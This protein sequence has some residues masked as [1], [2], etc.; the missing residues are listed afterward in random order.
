[1]LKFTQLE[2]ERPKPASLPCAAS[3]STLVLDKLEQL[4]PEHSEKT[5]EKGVL[6]NLS[7]RARAKYVT[8]I[9]ARPLAELKSPLQKAY[10]LSTTCAG[11]LAERPGKITS[12]YCG[13]RWC[14]VC[15]R[16]RT[17]KLING[18]LPA[19]EQMAEKWFLTLSRPNVPGTKLQDEIRY[20]LRE[21]SL[22][23]RYL[24]EKRN[25]KHYSS[26]R[27]IECTYNE[28]AQTYHPHF[29]IIFDDFE[30]ADL[31]L[32]QWL[33]RNPTAQLNKGN[34]LKKA[35]DKAVK[36]LFKYFTKV[37]SKTKSKAVNGTDSADYR[38]HLQA[39]DIMFVA[40][41]A[42]R[43]FQPCGI[44]K[45]V[46]EEIETEQALES[47]RVQVNQWSWKDYDWMNTETA[48]ALTGY[49]PSASI[50]SIS[51]HLV[52]PSSAPLTGYVDIET[53]E[54]LDLKYEP[55][56]R[57]SMRFRKLWSEPDEQPA[58]GV[59]S[60]RKLS[61]SVLISADWESQRQEF[62]LPAPAPTS[63]VIEGPEMARMLP[64]FA[65]PVVGSETTPAFL[66]LTAEGLGGLRPAQVG[67]RR[68]AP[69]PGASTSTQKVARARTTTERKPAKVRTAREPGYFT[70][71]TSDSPLFTG[72]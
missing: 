34:L 4:P 51:E 52:Y 2:R 62:E 29:H 32:Q 19:I 39:L 13:C 40:M 42:V 72:Q 45:A 20:Y 8:N 16:M 58:P 69:R 49:V 23:Q 18:Y 17:A 30:A 56:L 14:I 64:L 47:G 70:A 7:K 10:K 68:A 65:Q 21:A 28:Q 63:V 6:V 57:N 67:A 31:F 12:L 55:Q 61:P 60:R 43:T 71:L 1:M 54:V 53:G 46:S 9:V 50:Q 11:E 24:R 44:I 36:E 26:L 33:S 35:D 3:T 22:I 5:M 41:R 37:V 38:I 25:L 48:A 27:K 66:N 59:G 15:S